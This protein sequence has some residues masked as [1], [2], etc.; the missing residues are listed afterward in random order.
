MFLDQIDFSGLLADALGTLLMV[1]VFAIERIE[2]A[3]L[4]CFS[5]AFLKDGDNAKVL[6]CHRI[7]NDVQ[8]RSGQL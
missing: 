3:H 6:Q 4:A 7:G 5:I 1:V 2:K 8:T